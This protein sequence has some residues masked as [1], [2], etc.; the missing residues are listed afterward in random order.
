MIKNA[1]ALTE[2]EE[3]ETAAPPEG[4]V[5]DTVGMV[6]SVAL[7]TVTV[8]DEAVAVFPDASRATAVTV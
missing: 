1:M 7:E 8:T 5:I 3:P 4:A 2:T 6:V